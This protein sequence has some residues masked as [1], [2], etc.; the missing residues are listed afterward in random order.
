MKNGFLDLLFENNQKL[1]YHKFIFKMNSNKLSWIFN[2]D[3]VIDR[4]KSVAFTL[5]GRLKTPN[6]S[7]K[8]DTVVK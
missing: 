1:F 7:I 4:I 3:T 8:G 6:F 5:D 2:P